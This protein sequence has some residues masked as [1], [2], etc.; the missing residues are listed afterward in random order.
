M[1]DVGGKALLARVSAQGEDVITGISRSSVRVQDAVARHVEESP[2]R[3]TFVAQAKAVLLYDIQKTACFFGR[4]KGS[5]VLIARLPTDH[6]TL[7]LWSA[8]V[9][10]KVSLTSFGLLS[11]G[12][13]RRSSF[14]ACMDRHAQQQLERGPVP[15]AGL[16]AALVFGSD[17]VADRT[18]ILTAPCVNGMEGTV[19]VTKASGAML[20]VSFAKGSISVDAARCTSVYGHADVR[21][22]LSSATPAPAELQPL[23]AALSGIVHQVEPA[24]TSG[25][26]RTSASLE[27][28][29]AGRDPDNHMVL[30]NGRVVA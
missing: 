9:F 25:P 4:G 6:P 13:T 3:P 26:A 21:K 15:V 30:D 16:D 1:G 12:R 18:D 28:F 8:P 2:M 23:Y 27:R 14:V 10:V 29:S 7:I 11:F 19:G 20:D 24:C 22:I 5:G 17:S